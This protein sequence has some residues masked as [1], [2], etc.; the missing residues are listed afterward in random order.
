MSLAPAQFAD[1][2]Q[3]VN[4]F[5][6]FPWQLRLVH[7]IVAERQGY[8]P[9]LLTLPTSAGKTAAL[10][11]A[12]FVLALQADTPFG[13]RTAALRTFFVVDRRLVVDEAADRARKLARLL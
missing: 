7:E 5:A 10:D 12:L 3:S 4:G 8:W 2:F 6:P 9:P 1:F 11:V 13:E